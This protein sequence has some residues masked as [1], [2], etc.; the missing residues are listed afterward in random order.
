METVSAIAAAD[1]V[2]GNDNVVE[3]QFNSI[4]T[5]LDDDRHGANI[6]D[7]VADKVDVNN[8]IVIVG[9]DNGDGA[10]T[11]AVL[12]ITTVIRLMVMMKMML[13]C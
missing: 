2:D 9:V 4:V 1:N 8:D 6:E 12:L 7:A 3:D 13:Y 11:C 10:I 5:T